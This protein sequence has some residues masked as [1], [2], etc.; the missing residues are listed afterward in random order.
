MNK[1]QI[2]VVS[3]SHHDSHFDV[4]EKFFFLFAI[5]YGCEMWLNTAKFNTREI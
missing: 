2:I 1:R 4:I 3:F 5:F